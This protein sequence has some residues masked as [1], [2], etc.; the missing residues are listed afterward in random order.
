MNREKSSQSTE[1]FFYIKICKIGV[2]R[3]GKCGYNYQCKQEFQKRRSNEMIKSPVA[4][5]WMT[6]KYMTHS[7]IKNELL[8]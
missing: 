8:K 2:Y 7:T 5:K 1:G 6:T 4:I 3:D